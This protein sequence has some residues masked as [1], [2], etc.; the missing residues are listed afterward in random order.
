[1]KRFVS[2]LFLSAC[3]STL[4]AQTYQMVIRVNN[5]ATIGVP[6][7]KIS[8]P[9]DNISE[10]TFEETDDVQ[11]TEASAITFQFAEYSSGVTRSPKKNASK[12]ESRP[13]GVFGY[14]T[15]D[16]TNNTN[17]TLMENQKVEYLNDKWTYS[18]IKYWHESGHDL[19]RHSFF[20]YSPHTVIGSNDFVSINIVSGD[21]ILE[22]KSENPL[23][24]A[25]DLVY[26]SVT[27]AT[28]SDNNGCVNIMSKHALAKLNLK[29]VLAENMDKSTNTKVTIKSIKISGQI[30]NR[31]SFDLKRQQWKDLSTDVQTYCLEGDNLMADIRDAGY[32]SAAN[33]PE[34]I[35]STSKSIGVSPFLF[36]PTDGEKEITLTVEYNITTEDAHLH[37]GYARVDNCIT[38]K[39]N[40]SLNAGYSY[41]LQIRIGLTSIS[42]D[43]ISSSSWEDDSCVNLTR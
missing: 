27:N 2:F 19:V 21:P 12:L 4:M 31:G 15:T 14:Y 40:F 35:T 6:D 17:I 13:F 3:I 8:I 9:V 10:V 24:A 36:I 18:P 26:G 42:Y 11:P 7:G 34:G 33:Q 43:L 32:T 29:A 16:V 22:Y 5:G 30:P 39:L 41:D 20:A 1:M 37:E 38:K 25:G 28:K 23:N